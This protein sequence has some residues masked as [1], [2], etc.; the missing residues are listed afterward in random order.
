MDFQMHALSSPLVH[1]KESHD[2]LVSG[3]FR[4]KI[5]NSGLYYCA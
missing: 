2:V 3:Q 5:D 1:T 4:L